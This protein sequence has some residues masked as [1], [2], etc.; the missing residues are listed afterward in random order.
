MRELGLSPED[1]VH[2]QSGEWLTDRTINIAQSLLKRQYPEIGGLQSCLLGQTLAFDVEKGKFVQ[3]LFVNK[4]HW[5]TISN[6]N[7]PPE[8]I[9]VY[10]SRPSS[11]LNF[12][13]KEQIAALIFSEK[14]QVTLNILSLQTQKGPNDCGLFAIAYAQSLCSGKNPTAIH[15]LQVLSTFRGQCMRENGIHNHI[16][17]PLI[18]TASSSTA[19]NG[20]L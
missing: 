1:W 7:C 10:D 13:A 4:N 3:I 16:L 6:I 8:E 2:I 18:F 20:V 17:S 12:H 19:L 5:I 11:D 15:Y 14:K 9:N